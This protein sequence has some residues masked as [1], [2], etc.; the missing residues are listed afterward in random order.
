MALLI[1]LPVA[2]QVQQ[3]AK[4]P[5]I[6]FLANFDCDHPGGI[7]EILR[8]YGWSDGKTATFECRHAG[9]QPERMPETAA[10]LVRLKPDVILA[11]TN[12]AAFAAKQATR[13]I[14][15]VVYGA[16]GALET[17]LVPS[18]G[19]PGGNVTGVESLAPELDAKRLQLLRRSCRSLRSWPCATTPWTRTRP[20]I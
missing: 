5:R 15:I 4:S 12:L 2:S 13:T 18:L 10:E 1:G 17:G 3:A 8:G 14:P 6:G 16:H 19:R 20:Y 7:V 11:F 9:G